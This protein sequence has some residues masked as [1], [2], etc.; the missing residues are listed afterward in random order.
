MVCI[1]STTTTLQGRVATFF[2][3][4]PSPRSSMPSTMQQM[5]K[6]PTGRPRKT[7]EDLGE[8]PRVCSKV[9]WIFGGLLGVPLGYPLGLRPIPNSLCFWS[10]Q[11]RRNH[12]K[13]PFVDNMEPLGGVLL[14]GVW[15]P[16]QHPLC[17][18]LNELEIKPSR[19]LATASAADF[20]RDW[21]SWRAV[22]CGWQ[23]FVFGWRL[24]WFPVVSFVCNGS[25]MVSTMVQQHQNMT[26]R[27]IF[28]WQDNT[29]KGWNKHPEI[30]LERP[31]NSHSSRINISASYLCFSSSL[32]SRT[33]WSR[34]C[35]KQSSGGALGVWNL[36]RN[37]NVD[38]RRF[39][40]TWKTFW[41]DGHRICKVLHGNGSTRSTPKNH[42]L[43]EDI[44]KTWGPILRSVFRI[45]RPTPVLKSF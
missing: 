10:E 23:T 1:C 27:S 41:Q 28:C 25:N 44:N 40:S 8:K 33:S 17:H 15:K 5:P 4:L 42:G 36:A 35:A 29:I 32:R 43:M 38:L 16:Y 20:H 13:Y 31:M 12:K 7:T 34:T 11:T 9:L 24:Q 39:D 14:D 30:L 18:G 3:V 19:I 22:L 45:A 2:F 21:G 26:L 37:N 6:G